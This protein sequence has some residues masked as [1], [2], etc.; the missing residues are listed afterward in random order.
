MPTIAQQYLAPRD[1]QTEGDVLSLESSSIETGKHWLLI[2]HDGAA[3]ISEQV[4]GQPAKATITIPR[5]AFQK[6]L[7]WYETEQKRPT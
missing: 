5:R 4:L 6:M 7:A 2:Q 1:C 3:V